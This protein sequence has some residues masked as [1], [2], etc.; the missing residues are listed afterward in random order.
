MNDIDSIALRATS[1]AEPLGPSCT[2]TLSESA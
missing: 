1:S 2:F